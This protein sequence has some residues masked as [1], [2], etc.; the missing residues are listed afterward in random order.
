M[1]K[2]ALDA[3]RAMLRKIR[4]A[5]LS[6]EERRLLAEAAYEGHP[7]HK[8]NPGDFGLIP[9]SSPRPD[10]TLCDEAKVFRRADA[11]AL[12]ATATERGLVSEQTAANGW[13]K[14]LWLV[15]EDGRVFEATYGGSRPGRYHGY[16]IRKD[17]PF[18]EKVIEAWEA[19]R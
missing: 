3:K 7:H 8:R 2:R 15:D 19:N 18:F 17:D 10:K 11:E 13:P 12:F 5:V 16:P 14:H 4:N 1:G 9:P 6:Q